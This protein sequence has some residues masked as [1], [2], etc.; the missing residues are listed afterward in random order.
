MFEWKIEYH[1][2]EDILYLKSRGMMDVNG[3]NEMVRAL[4]ETAEAYQCHTHL[5]DHRETIFGFSVADFY[6]RPSINERLGISRTFRTAM[7]FAQLTDDTQF[8]EDV[9]QN[10]GYNLRHFVDVEEAKRWLKQE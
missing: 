10:R 6:E 9:F 4:I 7:V 5:V 1:G 3:A 2:D 8:M